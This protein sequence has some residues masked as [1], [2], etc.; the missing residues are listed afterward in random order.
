MEVTRRLGNQ[1]H[2]D[3][4]TCSQSSIQNSWSFVSGLL[5]LEFA[6]R[7]PMPKAV[8]Y[9]H[10]IR[11]THGD[12]RSPFIEAAF[13]CLLQLQLYPSLQSHDSYAGTNPVKHITI[14]RHQPGTWNARSQQ[15][16]SFRSA[17][18]EEPFQGPGFDPVSREA[19]LLPWQIAHC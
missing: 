14:G 18:G 16:T 13:G 1:G 9:A 4:G 2:I 11:L 17:L 19:L 12:D 15:I 8:Q 10:P 5:G 3:T 6:G 7:M